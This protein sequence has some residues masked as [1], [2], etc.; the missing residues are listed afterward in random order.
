MTESKRNQKG[1]DGDKEES[2]GR[3]RSQRGI[4]RGRTESEGSQ[5]GDDGVKEGS[6]GG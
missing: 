4:K 1:D 2:K 5:K 3:E 6:K